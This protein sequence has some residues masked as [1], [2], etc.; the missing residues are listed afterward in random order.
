IYYSHQILKDINKHHIVLGTLACYHGLNIENIKFIV[1][2]GFIP[3]LNETIQAIGRLRGSGTAYSYLLKDSSYQYYLSKKMTIYQQIC[4]V[5]N[6]DYWN[7]YDE[8][9]IN[10]QRYVL[11]EVDLEEF[12][13]MRSVGKSRLNS[14]SS[15]RLPDANKMM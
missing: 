1:F 8:T 7:K 13:S 3:Y 10:K 11:E 12:H 6:I 14:I 2:S 9:N 5:Y 4:K 15:H